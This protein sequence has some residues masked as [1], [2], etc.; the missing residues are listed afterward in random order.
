MRRRFRNRYLLLKPFLLIALLITVV[1]IS[2][3]YLSTSL[4]IS[5]NIT[6]H[7]T[8]QAYTITSDS[9]PDL[10]IDKFK[11]NK[12]QESGLQKIEYGFNLT[13]NSNKTYDNFKITI[14]F[15]VNVSSVNLWDYQYTLSNNILTINNS[16]YDL[17][18][19]NKLTIG[20]IITSNSTSVRIVSMKLEASS[21]SNEVGLDKFNVVFNKTNG[22]G[23]YI[24]QYDVTVT[25]KTGSKITFW[26]LEITFPSNTSYINGWNAIYEASGNV[27]LIKNT[28]SNGRLSNNGSTTFGLQLQTD[29]INFIPSNIKVTVR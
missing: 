6:G 20:F 29:I 21:D 1:G 3:A 22:W 19:H 26:Q 2:Y 17:K 10:G 18:A 5:G 11:I 8:N 7:T 27:L 9:N 24:Y 15:S 23:N 4:N 16:N 25:N 13:N 28:S 12:W 14:T